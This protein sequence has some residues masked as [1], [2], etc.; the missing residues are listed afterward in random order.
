MARSHAG[1]DDIHGPQW[2]EPWTKMASVSE[3]VGAIAHFP[4]GE[5]SNRASSEVSP[6]IGH[7][8]TPPI[9][10]T[11]RCAQPFRPAWHARVTTERATKRAVLLRWFRGAEG[12]K[13]N[14]RGRGNFT[15]PGRWYW[16]DE[17]QTGGGERLWE[18]SPLSWALWRCEGSID[19]EIGSKS[20]LAWSVNLAAFGLAAA[21]GVHDC[22]VVV[23]RWRVK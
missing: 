17:V 3:Y 6:N 20:G 11:K 9:R 12:R 7:T 16:A 13:A 1:R 22:R 10:F 19:V 21:L 15:Q 5:T 23:V 4:P 14:G 2:P 18:L 8:A